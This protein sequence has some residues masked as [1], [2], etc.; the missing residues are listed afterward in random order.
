[1]TFIPFQ[2]MSIRLE[3]SKNDSDLSYFYDLLLFGEY[4]TKI[5]NLFLV[6][7]INEDNERTRYRQEYNLVRANAIG[8]FAKSIDEI[9]TGPP[10]QLLSPGIRDLELKQLVQRATEGDWQFEAQKLLFETLGAF[11]IPH[12]PL[13]IKSPLRSWFNNFSLL[14]N[15]TKGHGATTIQPCSIA[16]PLLEKSINLIVS[17]FNGF[18]RPWCYLHRNYSGKYRVTY[19]NDRTEDYNYLK[20]EANHTLDN[21]VY[22]FIEQPRKINLILS[23]P[24][25]TDFYLTN[26]NLRGNKY[27]SISYLSDQRIVTDAQE[28]LLPFTQLPSSHTEGLGQLDVLGNSFTN[29]PD[30]ID[31]YVKRPLLEAELLKIL[32]ES[33]RFPVI[34][35]LGKGGVGKTSLALN[36]IREVAKDTRFDLIVWFSSRDIDLL[37]EGPKQVQTKVLNQKDISIEF[38]NLVFPDKEISDKLDYFSKELNKSTLGKALYIFDNFET[39]T[40]P[41]EVFEWINTYIRNPNKVLITSRI[42]RNFKA[43]YPIEVNG[44][45]DSECRMLIDLFSKKLNINHLLTPIYIEELILESDGHPYIIKILLGEVSKSGRISKIQRIVADQEKILTALFKRTFNTL[46][47]A[48]KRVF[49]TLCSWNSNV[50]VIAVEAVLW[51]PE[52]ERLDVQGAIEELRKSSFVDI[53]SEENDALINV[54]LAASIY[55][56]GELEVYPEKIKILDDRKLL[57]EFGA[58]QHGNLSTGVIHKIERKFTA[59]AKRTNSLKQ[60]KEELPT[61]EYIASKFPKAYSFII[62][63]LEE[64]GDYESAK[65]FLREYLKI[66]SSSDE[67]AKLWLQLADI[68]KL[69]KDWDGESHSLSE[70]ILLPNVSFEYISDASNRINNYFFYNPEAKTV[71]YKKLLLDKIIEVMIKRINEGTA[72]DYSRLSWLLVNNNQ[73]EQAKNYVEKGLKIDPD[74]YHCQRF[75]TRMFPFKQD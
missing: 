75:Y 19:I 59:V 39:V 14:R 58:S 62:D 69:T 66:A 54:P 13:P 12:T 43:D 37:M 7:S 15:K 44:M 2:Q 65:Y 28:Y 73:E 3:S 42:S 22:C 35:L 47:P 56:K 57:M 21:G 8:D 70:L 30:S 20:N 38:C 74:N 6:S 41:V 16:I 5:I 71:E 51:R 24:E 53:I 26:G 29:L 67:K 10:A 33:D 27:E 31:E 17:N 52:N 23:N 34:T 72:T 46:S 68:C 61:L 11:N 45:S 55:G 25:L 64:Y 9:L 18:K 63:I 1:M 40:N 48:A 36:V 50:P 4:V 32:V 49:L 60:F